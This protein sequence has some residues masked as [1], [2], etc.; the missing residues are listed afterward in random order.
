MQDTSLLVHVHSRRVTGREAEVAGE[1]RA[2]WYPNGGTDGLDARLRYCSPLPPQQV[3]L[4]ALLA[5]L[6]RLGHGVLLQLANARQ[7]LADLLQGPRNR[8]D[9]RTPERHVR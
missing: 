1:A 5:H 7:Q 6:Q 2:R 3:T 9:Q 8:T 4:C